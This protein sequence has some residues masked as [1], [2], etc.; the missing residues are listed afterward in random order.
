MG[1]NHILSVYLISVLGV[2][3]AAAQIQGALKFQ[4]TWS[5]Y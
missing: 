3:T 4:C 5:V 1:A 2:L